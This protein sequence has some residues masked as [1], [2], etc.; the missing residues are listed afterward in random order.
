MDKVVAQTNEKIAN[1][2]IFRIITLYVHD[3][4]WSIAMIALPVAPAEN[5][6][7]TCAF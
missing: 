3:Y 1:E 5:C 6:G 7:K 4:E 2:F